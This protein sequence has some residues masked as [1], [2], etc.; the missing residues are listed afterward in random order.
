MLNGIRR[1]LSLIIVSVFLATV[2]LPQ[3]DLLGS[4]RHQPQGNLVFSPPQEGNSETQVRDNNYS[5]KNGEISTTSLSQELKTRENASF[6][7]LVG[8][9]PGPGVFLGTI[10]RQ[11]TT[12]SA[13]SDDRIKKLFAGIPQVFPDLNKVLV[14]L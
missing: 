4:E 1:L 5:N 8:N 14:A 10:L 3:G 12:V 9:V 2:G 13:E 6:D 11:L 7:N